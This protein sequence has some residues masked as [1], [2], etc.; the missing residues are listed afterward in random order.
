[1]TRLGN[2]LFLLGMGFLVAM[3]SIAVAGIAINL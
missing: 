1:M 3:L 2:P